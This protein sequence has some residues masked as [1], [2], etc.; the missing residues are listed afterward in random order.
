MKKARKAIILGVSIVLIGITF[1][2]VLHRSN[3]EKFS[4]TEYSYSLSSKY[5]LTEDGL[6]Y[7]QDELGRYYDAN[8]KKVIPLGS[9]E[10][11][12]LYRMP[13]GVMVYQNRFYCIST[14]PTIISNGFVKGTL[15]RCD[16]DG[17][18]KKKIYDFPAGGVS[19]ICAY[20]GKL[21]YVLNS[22]MDDTEI[23][24]KHAYTLYALDL[25]TMKETVLFEQKETGEEHDGSITMCC[26]DDRSKLYFLRRYYEGTREDKDDSSYMINCFRSKF[27]CYDL[28][29]KKLSEC[30]KEVD[31]HSFVTS[32]CVYNGGL[33]CVRA[34]LTS[35]GEES[36]LERYDEK[37]GR[38]DVIMTFGEGAG[39]GT[40]NHIMYIYTE[41][42]NMIYD[43]EKDIC[44]KGKKGDS[45]RVVD[46]SENAVALDV[47]DYSDLKDGD[48][49][50]KS[51]FVP[52]IIPM[53]EFM[54]SFEPFDGGTFGNVEYTP[55]KG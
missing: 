43:F 54:S 44:Y 14:D 4:S 25:N 38:K 52:S 19:G 30:F 26:T 11:D 1:L 3:N 34:P 41:K 55:V 51:R 46:I 12:S 29:K 17:N 16:C 9:K 23:E 24:S 10:G 18:N 53:E 8:T 32:A 6:Y 47:G 13:V 7:I 28:K 15:Y 40:Y 37:T 21:Y 36:V 22:G 39:S 31:E 2:Y 35:E 5:Y 20:Q 45:F 48:A 42:G 33:Y 49:Y 27:Y 50:T